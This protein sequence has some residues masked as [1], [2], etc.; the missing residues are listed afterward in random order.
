MGLL[1]YSRLIYDSFTTRLAVITESLS[2]HY[3]AIIEPFSRDGGVSRDSDNI[4][5]FFLAYVEK[6]Q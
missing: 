3:R 2:N 4:F 5:L 1:F 6:K